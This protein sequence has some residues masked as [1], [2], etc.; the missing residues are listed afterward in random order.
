MTNYG[1]YRKSQRVATTPENGVAG[2]KQARQAV[3]ERVRKRRAIVAR[4][5]AAKIG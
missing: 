3:L 4:R 1:Q 2:R 5:L